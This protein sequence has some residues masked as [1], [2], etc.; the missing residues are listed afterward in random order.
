MSPEEIVAK[1]T[2]ALEQFE[3]IPGQPTDS[4]LTRLRE[5]LIQILLVV[6]FDEAD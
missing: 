5:V 4:D 2:E 3:Q 6:P 1:F